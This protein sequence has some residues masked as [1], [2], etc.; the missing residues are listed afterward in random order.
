MRLLPIFLATASL[1]VSQGSNP[2]FPSHIFTIRAPE[3]C[4]K[5]CQE[6]L[7]TRADSCTPCGSGQCLFGEECGTWA[8]TPNTCCIQPHNFSPTSSEKLKCSDVS[9]FLAAVDPKNPPSG[10]STPK[11]YNADLCPSGEVI[12]AYA[13][14]GG[15][16]GNLTC[17]ERGKDAIIIDS[18]ETLGVP[19]TVLCVNELSAG[20]SPGK[21]DTDGSGN[22][23]AGGNGTGTGSGTNGAERVVFGAWLV[24]VGVAAG[25]YLAA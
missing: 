2:L 11:I 5:D 14:F 18:A 24:V 4:D 20:A 23:D 17:C 21:K 22:K 16:D 19:E 7:C 15:A 3:P 1:V 8:G 9:A 6:A 12:A 13:V 10:S 25:L